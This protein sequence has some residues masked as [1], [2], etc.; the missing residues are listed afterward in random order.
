[1]TN[2]IWVAEKLQVVGDLDVIYQHSYFTDEETEAQRRDFLKVF[3][4]I[5]VADDTG[6]RC[7][8]SKSNVSQRPVP[9]GEVLRKINIIQTADAG[10]N[11]RVVTLKEIK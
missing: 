4:F 1:M 7:H 9:T 3:C 11:F 5:S 10:F 6:M 2:I 8:G